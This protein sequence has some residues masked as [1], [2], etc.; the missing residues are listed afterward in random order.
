MEIIDDFEAQIIEVYFYWRNANNINSPMRKGGE[1]SKA[2]RAI[3]LKAVEDWG[4]DAC[5]QAIDGNR[6]SA[7]HMGDNPEKRIWNDLG[8][9]LRDSDRD[10]G[11]KLE[12]FAR[13]KCEHDRKIAEAAER[14]A[15]ILERRQAMHDAAVA[16]S[17]EFN[18]GL[19]KPMPEAIKN[20]LAGLMTKIKVDKNGT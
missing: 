10:G 16:R 19:N 11:N 1:M 9:I 7:Y 6:L 4:V 12:K 15:K 14:D 17:E 20:Q 18:T 3:L 2:H 5:K 8:L 13:L